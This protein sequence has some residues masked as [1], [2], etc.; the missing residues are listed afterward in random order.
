MQHVL[1]QCPYI[2][3]HRDNHDIMASAK[4]KKKVFG[5]RIRNVKP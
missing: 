1:K 3:E 5:A 4:K 2:Y